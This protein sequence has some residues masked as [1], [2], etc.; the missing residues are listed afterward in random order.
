MPPLIISEYCPR[1]SLFDLL[2]KARTTPALQSKL[3]WG[4]RLRMVSL[5]HGEAC[6]PPGLG[7]IRLEAA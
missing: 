5:A 7:C 4:R 3:T 2:R 6:F 1:G